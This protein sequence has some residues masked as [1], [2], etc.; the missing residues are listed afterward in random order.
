M[1]A[2]ASLTGVHAQTPAAAPPSI[3]AAPLAPAGLYA[4]LG[5]KA[6]IVRLVDDFVERL[7]RHPRIGSQFKDTKPAALKES[8]VNQFCQLSG[9][10]CVYDGPEMG[11]LHADMD[12]NKGDFNALVE[13]LRPPWTPRA[14][15]S[16][17]RIACW[18]CWRPCTATSSRCTD[19]V[20]KTLFLIAACAISAGAGAGNVQFQVLD[21][22]G[23]AVPDAV[24]VLYP[25]TPGV[26]PAASKVT[27]GQQRMRFLPLVTVVA[28]G[29]TLHFTNLDRWDHHIRGTSAA[30]GFADA[31]A[32]A[33]FEMGLAGANPGTPGGEAEVTVQ[34]PGAMLRAAICTAPCAAMSLSPI[35]PGPSRPTTTVLPASPPYP[36]ALRSCASGTPSNW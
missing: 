27:I 14:S 32:G 2:S 31:S 16:P 23:R 15:L 36:K 12:I 8:L 21:K 7:V 18:R 20:K 29:S 22:E 17:S 19:M 33:D 30:Q 35:R 5:E 6:G 24:V 1:L 10:P 11:E 26:P 3:A 9:G 25:A 34:K 28:P 4:A 13:V